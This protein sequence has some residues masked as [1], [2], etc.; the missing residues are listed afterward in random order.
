MVSKKVLLFDFPTI[1]TKPHVDVWDTKVVNS[2]KWQTVTITFLKHKIITFNR[3]WRLIC[4][5]ILLLEKITGFPN[6]NKKVSHKN[7]LHGHFCESGGL[8]R[9]SIIYVWGVWEPWPFLPRVSFWLGIDGKWRKQSDELVQP[10]PGNPVKSWKRQIISAIPW[11][12]INKYPS[13]QS[14]R[15][16]RRLIGFSSHR[17]LLSLTH[18]HVARLIDALMTELVMKKWCAVGAVITTSARRLGAICLCDLVSVRWV[19]M[20]VNLSPKGNTEICIFTSRQA[21][22]CLPESSR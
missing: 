20:S 14:A 18:S 7:R 22:R 9:Y 1:F 15:G 19:L 5:A 4:F 12:I 13:G 10:P 16:E 17:L 21:A 11:Q 8:K 2:K 6:D 3:L